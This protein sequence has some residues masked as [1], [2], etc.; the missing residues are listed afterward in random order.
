MKHNIIL[1]I[2]ILLCFILFVGCVKNEMSP[3]KAK[4]LLIRDGETLHYNIY[5]NGEKTDNYYNLYRVYNSEE[6]IVVYSQVIK[7]GKENMHPE[8]Y[9]NYNFKLEVSLRNVSLTESCYDNYSNMMENNEK[10]MTYRE[11]IINKNSGQIFYSF[12]YWD[13]YTLK[14]SSGKI[15]YNPEYPIWDLDS[16]GMIGGRFLD[17]RGKGIIYV[18]EPLMSK[19]PIPV[20]F[21]FIGK[22]IIETPIGKFDTLK[23]GGRIADPF[24]GKLLE[25][26]TKQIYFWLE[27]SERGLMVKA[28]DSDGSVI[29]LDKII[30]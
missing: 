1:S 18:A 30:Q 27:D 9:S 12:K 15:K 10:G 5:K 8:N 7:A 17:M 2:F 3:M 23:I 16:I 4:K 11:I 21:N 14:S 13:G 29:I 28:I 20:S 6:R 24:L 26:F 25:G 19:T 22:E